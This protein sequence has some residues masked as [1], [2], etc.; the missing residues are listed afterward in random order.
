[1]ISPLTDADIGAEYTFEV[2]KDGI[3]YKIEMAPD[4]KTQQGFLYETHRQESKH[5]PEQVSTY[6]DF[7]FDEYEAQKHDL[8]AQ[9]MAGDLTQ[10]SKLHLDQEVEPIL[11]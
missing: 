11:G 4:D 2:T 5:G 9:L 6:W 8:S 3:T 10:F 7:T 1:M